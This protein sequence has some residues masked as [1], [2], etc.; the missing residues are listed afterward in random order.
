MRESLR[1]WQHAL[2]QRRKHLWDVTIVSFQANVTEGLAL[3]CVE[4]KPCGS[5]DQYKIGLNSESF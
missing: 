1:P 2:E 5:T 4:P 3:A